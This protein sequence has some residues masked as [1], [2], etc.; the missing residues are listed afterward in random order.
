M[1]TENAKVCTIAFMSRRAK[2]KLIINPTSFDLSLYLNCL[3]RNVTLTF[4]EGE[5]EANRTCTLYIWQTFGSLY[6]EESFVLGKVK[7]TIFVKPSYMLHFTDVTTE[8]DGGGGGVPPSFTMFLL[9][10]QPIYTYPYCV[11][12]C[13]VKRPHWMKSMWCSHCTTN[14]KRRG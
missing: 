1:K 7:A 13:W 8:K 2:Y 11:T 4:L 9:H 10:L 5:I 3:P 12:V 14:N 6:E